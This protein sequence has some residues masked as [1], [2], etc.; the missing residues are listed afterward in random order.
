M[1]ERLIMKEQ[2]KRSAVSTYIVLA[3][4]KSIEREE[5]KKNKQM[6]VFLYLFT[7]YDNEYEPPSMRPPGD[8]PVDAL[9]Q[10]VAR[11]PRLLLHLLLPSLLPLLLNTVRRWFSHHGNGA[12]SCS[13][14]WTVRPVCRF[15]PRDGSRTRRCRPRLKLFSY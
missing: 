1:C 13:V 5:K 15:R 7:D 10:G 6:C 14:Y 2:C 3:S 4:N 11:E 12:S 8:L 9:N